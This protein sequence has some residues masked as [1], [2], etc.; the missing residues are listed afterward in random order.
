MNWTKKLMEQIA[1]LHL[2]ESIRVRLIPTEQLVFNP[3]FRKFCEENTCHSYGANYSCPPYAGTAEELIAQVKTYPYV[4]VYQIFHTY[5]DEQAP[6]YK[7]E[8]IITKARMEHQKAGD[9]IQKVL[10]EHHAVFHAIGSGKCILCPECALLQ[11]Q[12][13]R[14]PDQLRKSMSAYCI[15]VNQLA[16]TC[17]LEFG[18]SIHTLTYFGLFCIGEN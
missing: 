10:E 11:N 17:G 18:D 3:L 9:Q 1:E 2:P 13:C 16:Q 7:N 15:D 12:P 6:V 5:P 4:I 14:K 8:K